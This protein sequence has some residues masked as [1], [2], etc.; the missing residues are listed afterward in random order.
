MGIKKFDVFIRNFDIFFSYDI[1]CPYPDS[2]IGMRTF[3]LRDG[4]TYLLNGTK[5]A[6]ITNAGIADVYFIL[7]R[8]DLSKPQQ[9]SL[10][11][12]Y[13][14]A[15]TPG[16]SFGNRTEMIGWKPSHHAEI[17]LDNDSDV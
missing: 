2:K 7:A 17:H 16:L 13:V 14:P 9:E 8:T 3:A 1:F 12:F 4:D 6:S 10:S 5:S 11:M 15:D